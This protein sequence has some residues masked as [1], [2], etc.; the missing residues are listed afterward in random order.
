M[1]AQQLKLFSIPDEPNK[2]KSTSH[3][4]A[5][6]LNF[7]YGP[8]WPDTFGKSLSE[9]SRTDVKHPIHTLSLFSGGGGLDIGFHDAGFSIH[10]MIE[11]EPRFVDTLTSNCGANNYFPNAAALCED[12]R[13]YHPPENLKVDFII[14][15][16]PCQTFS[17]AGRRAAGVQGTDDDRGMLF[18]EYVRLLI[19]LSPQGFLFENV[20]GITGAQNGDA[21][22]EIQKAFSGAGYKIFYRILDAADYGV[23]QH[24]ERL[25]IVGVKDG[26]FLFPRPTHGPDSPD[27]F[28]FYTASDAVKGVDLLS[29]EKCQTVGGRFGHLLNDIPPGLNYS[30]Y[31]QEMGHPTP[32]FSWRSKFSDFLYKADPNKPVRTIKA[33]GGQYTGPFHWNNRPFTVK[34]L[35]RLQTIPDRY[36]ISGGKQVAVHQIGNSVPPQIARILALAILNQVFKIP[37]PFELPLLP[38]NE[39]LGF[40]KRKRQLTKV[41]RDKAKSAIKEI[42]EYEQPLTVNPRTYI[43]RLS[44]DF[45]LEELSI[46]E[47]TED[48]LK[49]NF[50]PGPEIWHFSVTNGITHNNT[51]IKIVV[52]PAKTQKWDLPVTKVELCA[53]RLSFVLFTAL[54]KAFEVEIAQIGLKAD[55]VQL[56]GYYQYQPRFASRMTL[57]DEIDSVAWKTVQKVVKGIGTRNILST[58]TLSQMW[59][60]E[61]MTVLKLARKLKKIGYEVRN[62]HT[63]PQIPDGH[64]LIP[65][66]FPTLNPMSV[67]LRKSLGKQAG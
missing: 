55:L 33:Q 9:R 28:P 41:Y 35:K 60:V 32:V 47:Q 25:F 53:N 27:R 20:Y 12:I 5:K 21:W 37:L 1:Q 62:V 26:E 8:G 39:E 4:I 56:C 23:P 24:R 61:S 43:A 36:E 14:G 15:G 45:Y 29:E 17:A 16:P 59:E 22:L 13:N 52:H 66:T 30:F 11:I 65:Y 63:N 50:S 3:A 34:E 40:R 44:R 19:K 6:A 38:H 7:V 64:F 57:P 67:Q 42:G 46:D 54:W 49:I 48:L 58:E 10:T 51:N 18:E 2:A 31:T